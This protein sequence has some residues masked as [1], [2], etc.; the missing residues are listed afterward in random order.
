[1][2][3]SLSGHRSPQPLEQYNNRC[4][5]SLL[6]VF[7]CLDQV[8]SR[9]SHTHSPH[10]NS[11]MVYTIITVLKLDFC[12]PKKLYL[13]ASKFMC[14]F[15]CLFFNINGFCCMYKYPVKVTLSNHNTVEWYKHDDVCIY[16]WRSA[17]LCLAN[18]YLKP[19]EEGR[20]GSVQFNFSH[21]LTG[22]F[23]HLLTVCT[24][25]FCVGILGS[26]GRWQLWKHLSPCTSLQI[27]CHTYCLTL[28][29]VRLGRAR[30]KTCICQSL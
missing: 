26:K 9:I 8:K 22:N 28:R 21:S 7:C 20:C 15:V 18:L 12:D 1:M 4:T 25:S 23:W 16:M 30:K 27:W 5:V 29:K 2:C 24:A 6:T 11:S 14:F 10:T 19:E 17:V 13:K 3:S